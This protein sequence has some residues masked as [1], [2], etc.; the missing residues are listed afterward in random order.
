MVGCGNSPFS[1]Q[2]YDAG[3]RYIT[4]LDYSPTVIELM[5]RKYADRQAMQWICTDAINLSSEVVQDQ[6][7]DII[8]DK[9]CL[10]AIVEDETESGF[11]AANTMLV[12]LKRVLHVEREDAFFILISL[13]APDKRV[14]LLERAGWAVL[15]YVELPTFKVHSE[16]GIE[17]RVAST[18]HFYFCRPTTGQPVQHDDE[19]VFVG[20]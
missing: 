7:M 4:N 8:L 13:G 16:R 20:S 2:L 19:S 12:G 9:G 17:A 6:S 10:D 5:K 18:A 15:Q 14:P 3:Y 11:E 1:A